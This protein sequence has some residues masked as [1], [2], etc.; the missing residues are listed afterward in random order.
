[1]QR[2]VP[3]EVPTG[4]SLKERMGPGTDGQRVE[5]GQVDE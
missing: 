5:R 3:K 2:A 4:R 1:M